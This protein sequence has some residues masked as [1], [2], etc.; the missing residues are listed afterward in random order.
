MAAHMGAAGAADNWQ[1]GDIRYEWWRG[2]RERRKAR[3]LIRSFVA[4]LL[5][6]LAACA[7]IA[8][9]PPAQPSIYVMRHLHTPKGATDP[10]LTDEGQRYAA[11]VSQWFRRDPPDVIYVSSTRRAQQTVAPLAQRLQ[12]I[13]I[14]YDPRDTPGLLDS[15]AKQP[16]T[17]LVVGH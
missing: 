3:M 13:P 6:A 15:V 17:V 9:P 4:A 12:L 16:G 2:V 7:T 10:D 1:Q 14:I 11:A 5:F 8:T